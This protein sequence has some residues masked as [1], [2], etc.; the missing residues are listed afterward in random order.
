MTGIPQI[1]VTD[2]TDDATLLDVREPD[3]WQA[4]HAPGAVLI[5]LRDLPGRL[6]EV[7]AM[8]EGTLAIVC[9]SGHRSGQATAWLT[10]QGYDVTNVAGGMQAWQRAGKAMVTES[11][12]EPRVA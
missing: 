1:D 9:R 7:A 4:G 12:A 8:G 10:R 2:V 3:E 5:P 11:G 6:A